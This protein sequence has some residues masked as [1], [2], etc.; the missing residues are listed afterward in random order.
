MMES[1]LRGRKLWVCPMTY[2]GAM[3]FAAVWRSLGVEADVIPPSDDRKLALAAPYLSGDECLPQKVTLGDL[4]GVAQRPDF[5][6]DRTAFFFATADGPCRFGQYLSLFRKVFRDAGLGGVLFV[7]PNSHDAYQGLGREFRSL[8]RLAWQA[9]VAGDILQK[10][11]LRIRP[12]EVERGAADQVFEESLRRLCQLIERPAPSPTERRRE[13][14]KSLAEIGDRFR[15]VPVTPARHPLIGVVGEIFCRLHTFSNQELIRRFE[16]LGAEV[17]LSD[18]SEWIWYTNDR[19]EHRLALRGRS[20]S[21]AM[22]GC[23]IRDHVQR[24]DEHA[25][26]SS[27]RDELRGREEPDRISELLDRAR[28]YLPADGA[29][30]EMILSVGKAIYLC[31]KGA[32]AVI[33]ISPFTCMN[34]IVSE[35]IYPKLSR[36]HGGFPV[37][38]IFFDGSPVNLE[39][40][41]EIFLEL[42]R[43]YRDRRRGVG[44]DAEL[45]SS[46]AAAPVEAG[47]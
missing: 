41:L 45:R 23:R 42:A 7:A 13:L 38:T 27:V 9:L 5:D 26:Y 14:V 46:P 24:A 25:L 20:L 29:M 44:T 10:L 3:T 8:T 22:L 6:P 32:D 17:W 18:L 4:L 11:L 40:D 47:G 43:S 31:E 33:D 15:R 35:A 36:V 2:A 28:P 39:R 19:E 34:G 37:K 30:G 12:Y 21:F 1:S 16:R